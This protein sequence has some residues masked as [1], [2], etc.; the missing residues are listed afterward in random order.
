[1]S[2]EGRIIEFLDADNPKLGY[3]RKQEHD[4]LHVIDTRGRNLSVNGDRVIAIHG[5][6]SESE[7]PA[8]AKAIS[9]K[10]ARR[11]SEVDVELLWQS[12]DKTDYALQPAELGKLFF[13]EE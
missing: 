9:E 10:V 11:R 13:A 2:L 6:G 3:V 4:K 12:L 8:N 1:M 7:F 5:G